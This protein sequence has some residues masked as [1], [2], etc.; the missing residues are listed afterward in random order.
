MIEFSGCGEENKFLINRNKDNFNEFFS[1]VSKNNQV[2]SDETKNLE[3]ELLKFGQ[4]SE[5]KSVL[6]GSATDGLYF[7]LLSVPHL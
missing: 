6:V 2:R 5:A 3:T 4:C 7:S 1:N